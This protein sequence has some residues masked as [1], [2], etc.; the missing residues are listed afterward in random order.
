MEEIRRGTSEVL[1]AAKPWSEDVG[2]HPLKPG[3]I[4]L[5]KLAGVLLHL[6]NKEVVQELLGEV[7]VVLEVG[8]P[9]GLQASLAV[10]YAQVRLVP[11]AIVPDSIWLCT[12]GLVCEVRVSFASEGRNGSW[13]EAVTGATIG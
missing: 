2:T 10:V 13:V 3:K 5:L 1:R 7:A 11:G 12:R 8:V 9:E 4:T 6:W